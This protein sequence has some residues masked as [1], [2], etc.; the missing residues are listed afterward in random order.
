MIREEVGEPEVDHLDVDF[1][2]LDV[3]AT[4]ASSDAIEE[5][6]SSATGAGAKAIKSLVIGTRSNAH[7]NSRKCEYDGAFS[8]DYCF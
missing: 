4:D 3:T 6:M 1:A 5:I 2:L 7:Y 8:A